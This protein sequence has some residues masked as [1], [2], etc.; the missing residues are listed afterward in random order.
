MIRNSSDVYLRTRREY[1]HAVR[2]ADR[3][4]SHNMEQ[5][6]SEAETQI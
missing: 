5:L 6:V 3:Q 4:G 1:C 2:A